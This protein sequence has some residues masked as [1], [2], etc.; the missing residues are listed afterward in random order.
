MG[1]APA[2]G[3]FGHGRLALPARRSKRRVS[4]SRAEARRSAFRRRHGKLQGPRDA[5]GGRNVEQRDVAVAMLAQEFLRP[6]KIAEARRRAGD[7]RT[8]T[9]C[10]AGSGEHSRGAA[11][12]TGPSPYRFS[13]LPGSRNSVRPAAP[14]STAAVKSTWGET[15]GPEGFGRRRSANARNGSRPGS[16]SARSPPPVHARGKVGLS[17]D[18]VAMSVRNSPPLRIVA[19]PAIGIWSR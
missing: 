19:W 16:G 7:R 18:A 17:T 4:A 11:A 9:C 8:A 5:G 14:G 15:R 3:C 13:G 2:H 6:A 10:S 1:E 12:G